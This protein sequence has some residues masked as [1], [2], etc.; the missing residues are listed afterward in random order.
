MNTLSVESGRGGPAGFGRRIGRW[1]AGVA[2]AASLAT[3]AAQALELNVAD[4]EIASGE[5]VSIPVR[6]IDAK[7]LAA[8]QMQLT[9]DGETLEVTEVS[10]GPALPNALVDFKPSNGSCTVAFASS[11]PVAADGDLLIVKMRRKAGASGGS[12]VV[13]D[14]VRAWGGDGNQLIQ[15]SAHPGHVAPL[16]QSPSV[17]GRSIDWRYLAGALATVVVLAVGAVLMLARRGRVKA[18]ARPALEKTAP[19]QSPPKPGAAPHFCTACGA[20]LTEDA[21]YCPNCGVKI[22]RA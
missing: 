18:S 13:A 19:A 9:F 16:S 15:V 21:N 2:L 14:N 17:E 10:A 5:T 8:L 12:T 20:P 11:D 22:A 7:G 1:F 3:G 6:A 4:V